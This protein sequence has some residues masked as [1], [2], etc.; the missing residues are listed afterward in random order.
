M[1]IA[2]LLRQLLP[3]VAYDPNGRHVGAVI[4]AEAQQIEAAIGSSA[5]VLMALHPETGYALDDWERVLSLPEPCTANL[6]LTRAQRVAAVLAKLA[7]VQGQRLQDYIDL[8][9]AL[10]YPGA[11]VDKF[12]ARRYGRARHG[13]RYGGDAWNCVFRLNL[14]ALQ[15]SV[16]PWRSRPWAS[17]IEPGATRSWNV[18]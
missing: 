11:T 17:V 10:G 7:G 3:P 15:V 1:T 2:E 12:H 18:P 13:E 9:T 14:P 5:T 4:D 8:A 6:A 16:P